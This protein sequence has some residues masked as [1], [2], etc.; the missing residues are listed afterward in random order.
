MK[1]VK[2]NHLENIKDYYDT[3]VEACELHIKI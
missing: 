3:K 2:T 1:W